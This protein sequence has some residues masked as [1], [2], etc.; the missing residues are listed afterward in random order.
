MI[1]RIRGWLDGLPWSPPRP[2]WLEWLPRP[3]S[4]PA[5]LRLIERLAQPTDETLQLMQ[6]LFQEGAGGA[7]IIDRAGRIVRANDALRHMLGRQAS[8]APGQ[9]SLA[10]FAR[11][12]REE[13]WD[14]LV[15]VLEGR[16]LPRPFSTRLDKEG[17]DSDQTVDVCGVPVREADGSVSGLVLS[18]SDITVQKQLEAQLS[19]SQKLQ[20]VGQL[21]GGIAHDF[22]NLLTAIIGAADLVAGREKDAE[23]L[24]DIA[25][26]RLSADRGAAL[27]RQLLAFGRQQTLQPK[28]I[29]VNDTVQDLS[30]LLRRLL[31]TKVRLDLDLELPG[32]MVRA[33]PT[34]LDQVLVNLAVNARDAMPDGGTLTLRTGHITLFRALTRGQETIPPG[35]YVMIEAQDTGVGIP[36]EV[37]PRIF[38]PFFTTKRDRGGNGLGLSTVH[39]I[40]RQSDGFLAV[41]SQP[42]KG[43]RLRVYLPRYDGTE[44]VTIP[45]SPRSDIAPAL[46]AAEAAAE[47]APVAQP[48]ARVAEPV[49]VA[50]PIR[51]A[52]PVGRAALLVDDE[53]PVRRLA[54]RAMLRGGWRVFAAGSAEQALQMLEELTQA[55]SRPELAV[56]ITDVVMPGMDGPSLVHKVRESWPGLPAI[57]VSGY[58]EETLRRDLAA[59]GMVFLPKPYTLKALLACAE[60]VTGA[61]R[62]PGDAPTGEGAPGKEKV[63]GFALDSPFLTDGGQRPPDPLSKIALARS[64]V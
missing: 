53:D 40:I 15:P 22:N 4:A 35:R 21:A 28:V 7:L 43:T 26:I 10:I 45:R 16:R 2:G 64:S 18:L 36:P 56:M 47:P 58:A 49:P 48:P 32:R 24:E 37:L 29:S 34:Q 31:G 1:R 19:Q 23:T 8:L 63:E 12:E 50:E 25:Q 27:V 33:D 9:P 6:V 13:V 62:K 20:A 42:G 5:P 39:G 3:Q 55:G 61:G 51:A 60:Q 30:S 14:E 46:P 38:D 11:T 41:D 17:T 59:A 54:E 44:S 52:E 57:L